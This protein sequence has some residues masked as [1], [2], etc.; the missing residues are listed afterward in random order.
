MVK[1]TYGHDITS[2]DDPHIVL[3]VEAGNRSTAEG[4][5]G[6]TVIDIVPIRE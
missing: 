3:A 4:Q 6:A 1:A 2:D 5:P